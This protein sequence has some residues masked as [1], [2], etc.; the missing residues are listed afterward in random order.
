MSLQNKAILITRSEDQAQGLKNLIELHGGNAILF[1]TIKIVA[2]DTWQEC[3]KALRDIHLFDGIIFTSR[4]A[5]EKF[6]GRMNYLHISPEILNSLLIFAVGEKT[7]NAIENFNIKTDAIPEKYTAEELSEIIKTYS[8]YG[9]NFLFPR[10][11]LARETVINMLTS[12]GA[13]VR[14]VTVYKTEK[15]DPVNINEIQTMIMRNEI[16]AITFTSPSTVHNF[17]SLLNDET[18]AAITQKTIFAVIGEVTAAALK[19]EGYESTV[20]AN[21]STIDALIS[22]IESYFSIV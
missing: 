10:G 9:K 12:E 5:V 20:I 8:L 18:K 1:P 3:D 13:N 19:K 11:N 15:A 7:G 21:P 14:G 4:N 16:D 17:F 2:P 22:K 6:F